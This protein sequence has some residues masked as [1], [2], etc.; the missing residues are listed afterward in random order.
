MASK[1]IYTCDRCGR[2]TPGVHNV[3]LGKDYSSPRNFGGNHDRIA[4]DLCQDCWQA[5]ADFMRLK[6]SN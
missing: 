6:T 1:T 3:D 4:M 5:L 2:E